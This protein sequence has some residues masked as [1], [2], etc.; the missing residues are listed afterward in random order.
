MDGCLEEVGSEVGKSASR[1]TRDASRL[2][3][4]H[5]PSLTVR[6]AAKKSL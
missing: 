1:M 5:G 6:M 4:L 2:C 3:G